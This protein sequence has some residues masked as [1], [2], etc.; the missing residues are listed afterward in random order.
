MIYGGV[1][2]STG[3]RNLDKRAEVR[4]LYKSRN[5]NINANNNRVALAA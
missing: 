2:V 3:S 4:Y 5:L 1:K